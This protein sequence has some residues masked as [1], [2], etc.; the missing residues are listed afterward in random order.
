MTRHHR[1][2]SVVIGTGMLTGCLLMWH[3]T[4]PTA[5]SNAELARPEGL[6]QRWTA[7]GEHVLALDQRTQATAGLLVASLASSAYSPTV[8]A[9]GVVLEPADAAGGQPDARIELFLPARAEPSPAPSRVAVR[10]PDGTQALAERLAQDPRSPAA[11]AIHRL[12]YVVRNSGETFAPG[13]SVEVCLPAGLERSGVIVPESA[14]VWSEGKAWIYL[15]QPR[16]PAREAADADQTGA[17]GQAPFVRREI[18][19]D[20]PVPHGWFVSGLPPETRVVVSGAQLLLS[21][22]FE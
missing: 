5:P 19:T 3:A 10:A 11:G 16:E 18:P 12:L 17:P 13:T 6:V 21:A 7:Q 9:Q 20:L 1:Q 14:V 4:R 22:E 8:Q 2:Q 15:Q